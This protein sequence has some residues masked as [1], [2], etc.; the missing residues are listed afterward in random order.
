MTSP[1]TTVCLTQ[2]A[3]WQEDLHLIAGLQLSTHM[4]GVWITK[5][6]LDALFQLYKHCRTARCAKEGA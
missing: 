5:K 3:L 2:T 6:T 1:Q 4:C